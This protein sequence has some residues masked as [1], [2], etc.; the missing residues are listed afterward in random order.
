MSIDSKLFFDFRKEYPELLA[1]DVAEFIA[2]KDFE[3]E[4][5]TFKGEVVAEEVLDANGKVDYIKYTR[6]GKNINN[7]RGGVSADII[8]ETAELEIYNQYKE[9]LADFIFNKLATV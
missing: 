2:T 5:T 4:K 6:N 7:V 8:E 1:S 9:E 3:T